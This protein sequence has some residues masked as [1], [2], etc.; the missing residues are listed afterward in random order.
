MASAI[1][2]ATVEAIAE[3]LDH[4]S[5]LPVSHLLDGSDA[6]LGLSVQLQQIGQHAGLELILGFSRKQ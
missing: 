3:V 5:G 4:G 6:E 2:P 1:S